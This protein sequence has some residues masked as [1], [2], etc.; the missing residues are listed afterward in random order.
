ML[1][2]TALDNAASIRLLTQDRLLRHRASGDSTQPDRVHASMK[3]P[4]AHSIAAR[5]SVER[6]CRRPA[7]TPKMRMAEKLDSDPPRG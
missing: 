6:R 3:V 4:R 1:A 2:E 7:A 5:Q